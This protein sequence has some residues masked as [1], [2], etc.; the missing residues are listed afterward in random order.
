MNRML[1]CIG[2]A[3]VSS[4]MIGVAVAGKIAEPDELRYPNVISPR[5]EIVSRSY[6]T[7]GLL[8]SKA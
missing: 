2:L 8:R 3:V 1:V 5:L 4:L 6:D 7:D